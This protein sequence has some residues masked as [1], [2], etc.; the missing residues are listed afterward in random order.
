M[1]GYT[2]VFFLV[3]NTRLPTNIVYII[4][5]YGIYLLLPVVE[6]ITH[7]ESF[8]VSGDLEPV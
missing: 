4:Q 2:C 5:A 6:S 8:T 3:G 7:Q 1:F